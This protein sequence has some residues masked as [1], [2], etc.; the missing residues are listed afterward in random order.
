[1]FFFSRST[2]CLLSSGCSPELMDRTFDQIMALFDSDQK[3]NLNAKQS[4]LS[5][6][7]TTRPK[8]GLIVALQQTTK[9][10]MGEATSHYQTR[11]K[12]SR[13]VPRETPRRCMWT[14]PVSKRV[15]RFR[16]NHERVLACLG[17]CRSPK[18][19]ESIGHEFGPGRCSNPVAQMVLYCAIHPMPRQPKRERNVAL[20]WTVAF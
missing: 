11:K 19:R 8:P 14:Q 10:I 18:T 3:E 6:G 1:M 20:I 7:A 16:T 2:A 9:I 17:A 13:L 15:A 4:S 12:V 5:T